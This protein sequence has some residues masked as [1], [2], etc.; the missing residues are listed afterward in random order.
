MG[1]RYDDL[2]PGEIYHVF[3]RTVERRDVFL[4]MSDYERFAALLTHCIPPGVIKSFSLA[5]RLGQKHLLPP[6]GEGLIDLLCFCLM[7]NH[8]HLLVRE[9]VEG[10]TSKYMKRLLTSYA[11]YFNR[12]YSRSGSLFIHPF[13][14]VLIDGD[15]Q[16]LQVSRYIHLN[17]YVAHMVND[18]FA[19]PWS[20]LQEYTGKPSQLC[21]RDL[22][23]DIMSPDSYRSFVSD[24]ADYA[25][26]L[27][28]IHRLLVDDDESLN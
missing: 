14:A 28:D 24:E 20:S 13:K 22:L 12:R 27:G 11:C 16:F 25:R 2:A 6:S 10:G 5:K 3:T 19:Y 7:T 17:P 4:D 26:S 1:Y 15:E 21:H 9:N 23:I 18:V 8:V